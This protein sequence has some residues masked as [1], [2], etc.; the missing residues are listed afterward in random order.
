MQL[1]WMFFNHIRFMKTISV[2]ETSKNLIFR[3]SFINIREW[4]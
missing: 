2:M 4:L 1:N 3:S